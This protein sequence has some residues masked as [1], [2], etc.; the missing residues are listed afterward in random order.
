MYTI[1]NLYTLPDKRKPFRALVISTTHLTY[2]CKI[3][4]SHALNFKEEAYPN[5]H[6][7]QTE[8]TT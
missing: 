1:E 3:L 7:V 5:A 2:T 6:Y 4:R 8:Q